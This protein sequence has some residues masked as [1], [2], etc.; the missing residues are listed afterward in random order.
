MVTYTNSI[1]CTYSVPKKKKKLTGRKVQN[2]FSLL[3][4]LFGTIVLVHVVYRPTVFTGGESNII[5]LTREKS[6]S[7][8]PTQAALKMLGSLKMLAPTVFPQQKP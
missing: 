6:N 2:I 5:A 3:I 8:W 7:N 4:I 1:I